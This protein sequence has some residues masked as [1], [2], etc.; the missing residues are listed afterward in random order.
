MSHQ[1]AYSLFYLYAISLSAKWILKS[2]FP[3]ISSHN[4]NKDSLIITTEILFIILAL[5]SHIYRQINTWQLWT[6]HSFM[7]HLMI[8][9]LYSSFCEIWISIDSFFLFLLLYQYTQLKRRHSLTNITSNVKKNGK[10]HQS[11]FV[12]CPKTLFKYKQKEK[13]MVLRVI[14]MCKVGP[15]PNVAASERRDIPNS[16]M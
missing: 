1:Y 8:I 14:S 16:F 12:H 11:P 5:I 15:C 2:M 13:D 9:Y 4:F 6:I 10:N 7:I 3:S